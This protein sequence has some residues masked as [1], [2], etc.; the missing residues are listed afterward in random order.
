MSSFAYQGRH[1]A[2]QNSA[3]TACWSGVRRTAPAPVHS[4]S[5][6]AHV[7]ISLNVHANHKQPL[8]HDSETCAQVPQQLSMASGTVPQQLSMTSGTDVWSSGLL[9]CFSDCYVMIQTCF[10]PCVTYGQI[11]D[12]VSGGAPLNNP[13]L[14]SSVHLNRC[15]A[16]HK[17]RANTHWDLDSCSCVI[18]TSIKQAQ[19]WFLQEAP[20]SWRDSRQCFMI[21][22]NAF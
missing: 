13:S 21:P 20:G 3:K 17:C 18:C 2:S 5:D 6:R 15:F 11:V 19:L 7:A 16:P 12:R 14:H 8:P 9:D 4:C 1:T 10:L 22:V